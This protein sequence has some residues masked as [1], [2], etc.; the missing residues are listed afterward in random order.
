[1]YQ[2]R[3]IGQETFRQLYRLHPDVKRWRLG[4]PEFHTKNRH[5]YERMGFTY[6]ETW[7][8]EQ[9]AASTTK[10]TYSY[11][12]RKLM[13]AG[14]VNEVGHSYDYAYEYGTGT[15]LRTDGPNVRS[16][17]TGPL[18]PLDGTHPLLE[19]RTIRV[20]GL[21]RPIERFE[22][23]SYAAQLYT[24]YLVETHQYVDA[25]I[26]GA[27]TSMRTHQLQD[28]DQTF[29]RQEQTEL[30]GHGRPIKTT[31]FT[32]APRPPIRSPRCSIEPTARCKP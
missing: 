21:G 5:F 9:N 6:L 31:V 20:D 11:D 4:T 3:G 17:V 19:Q 24:L 28:V 18:C 12:A 30:D 16:C 29:W 14:E 25:I 13:V 26:G 2:D 10:T 23:V 7:K 22:T 1:M 8:P 27:P 15:R 32:Q